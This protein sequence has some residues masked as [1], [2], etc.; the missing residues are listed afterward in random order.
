MKN[1]VIAPVGD[2]PD[3]LF[4]GIK[5]FPTSRVVLLSSDDTLEAARSLKK[6]LERFR[7][8]VYV[9]RLAKQ[10]SVWEDMFQAI[11]EVRQEFCLT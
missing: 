11:S 2:N 4:I 8:P 7:V 1:V 3:A 10:G 5:E 6:D 9:K